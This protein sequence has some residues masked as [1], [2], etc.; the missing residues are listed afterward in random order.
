MTSNMHKS[1]YITIHFKKKNSHL[2]NTL[3]FGN[4]KLRSNGNKSYTGFLKFYSRENNDL[5]S[6]LEILQF[7]LYNFFP[8]CTQTLGY[9][10]L[11]EVK[12]NLTEEGTLT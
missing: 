1:F 3:Q 11:F 9:C 5:I 8:N 10:E 6:I 2:V 4:A 7:F 12:L